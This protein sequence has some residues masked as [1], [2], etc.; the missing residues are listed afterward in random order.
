MT[1]LP[2]QCDPITANWNIMVYIAADDALAGFAVESLRQLRRNASSNVV[3][4]AQF[5]VDGK[6]NIPRYFFDGDPKKMGPLDE[7]VKD[8]ITVK[9]NMADP[10]ALGEFIDWAYSQQPA[11]RYA[12]VLWGHGP[13][14]L[15]ENF[16]TPGTQKE[17]TFLT[18]LDLKTALAQ[19][20]KLKQEK[21]KLDI[22]VIDACNMSMM[23]TALEVQDYVRFLIASQEDV[24]DFSFSYES[25]LGAFREATTEED[26]IALCKNAPGSYIAAYLDFI[27]TQQEEIDN[28]TLSSFSLANAAQTAEL[29]K[30]LAADLMKSINDPLIPQAVIAAR[31]DSKS[32][33]GGLYVDLFDFCS[34]LRSRV[35]AL[36]GNGKTPGTR[37]D[38]DLISI[39][40][41]ICDE[42]RSRADN[43]FVIENEA[44][45]DK[46]CNGLSIYF[47]YVTKPDSVALSM[48]L[49]GPKTT[50]NSGG[51][52]VLIKNS[53]ADVLIKN[54][55]S[56]DVPIKNSADVLNTSN[57]QM[58]NK[59][60]LQR[61]QE[62]EGYYQQLKLSSVTG[63]G[64]FI[65]HGW[66]RY[67]AEAVEDK[68]KPAPFVDFSQL[69]DQYYSAQQC[70]LNLLS[71]C[72]ELEKNCPAARSTRASAGR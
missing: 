65:Q 43:A 20:Q 57:A 30:Q 10:C 39:C 36:N 71:L 1:E 27:R 38:S 52:D 12:L 66:S 47:P 67:L 7:N 41:R 40:E 62:T 55:G 14:L 21:R 49:G 64:D 26:I 44:S 68:V 59:I 53:G 45:K 34:R 8:T 11:K 29:V 5:D 48:P 31:A 24:P 32:F 25:L 6:R 19:S 51:T 42:I 69:L 60:R 23:E 63:W 56:T 70:A 3:V 13:E 58:M 33:V 72:H 9:T 18:P 28:I 46:T 35:V 61:I 17:K 4:T 50:K 54:S 15:L 37:L 2:R 22:L 16:V